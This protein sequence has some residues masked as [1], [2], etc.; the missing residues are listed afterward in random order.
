MN[1]KLNGVK[2]EIYSSSEDFYELN[3][4]EF[5]V[6]SPEVLPLDIKRMGYLNIPNNEIGK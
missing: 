5:H 4:A 6:E 2:W 3:L 1:L